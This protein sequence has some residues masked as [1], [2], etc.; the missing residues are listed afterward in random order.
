MGKAA[1]RR[2]TTREYLDAEER[3]EVRHEY[4]AGEIFAMVGA[5]IRHDRLVNAIRR[6][7]ERHA[8]GRGCE[9]F[10][11]TT[12]LWV[13]AADCFYYPDLFVSCR[14]PAGSDRHVDNAVLVVEVLS[15]STEAIDR[16][17]KR[18]NY[19]KLADLQ[20]YVLVSQDAR[21]IEVQRRVGGEW[22]IEIV[23]GDDQV[24][25]RSIGLQLTLAEVY[26]EVGSE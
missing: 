16:R 23:T 12:R 11:G 22:E 10:S 7:V 24:T 5:F 6:A 3:S 21:R 20:E 19:V 1:I 9:V 4:V 15:E 13:E 8:A 26:R 2:L 17:E 14:P 25:L 18:L